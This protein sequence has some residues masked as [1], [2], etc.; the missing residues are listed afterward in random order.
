LRL[1]L[2]F[3][4][5]RF[6]LHLLF[7]LLFFFLTLDFS[8][9][10]SLH[11]SQSTTNLLIS[12]THNV[13]RERSCIWRTAKRRCCSNPP[14]TSIGLIS[15]QANYPSCCLHCV[16]CPNTKT[17]W[18]CF[19]LT[20]KSVWIGLSSSVIVF[21]KWLL[22]KK[23]FKYRKLRWVNQNLS[24]TDHY[25]QPSLLQH[26]ILSLPLAWPNSWPDSQLCS[27]LGKKSQWLVESTCEQSFLSVSFSAWVWCSATWLIFIYQ[28]L[29]FR[30]S[31]SAILHNAQEIISN[32][33]IGHHSSCHS[34]CYVDSWHSPS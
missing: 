24:R 14:T 34:S 15:S 33:Y 3:C 28:S 25:R 9:W 11:V 17:T 6:S 2:T 7:Q 1:C 13:W 26:G 23:G 12:W 29:L 5:C 31:R 8:V 22:D 4:V 16:R 21:N 27:T 32:P 18:N 30:C 19:G 20:W 10:Y